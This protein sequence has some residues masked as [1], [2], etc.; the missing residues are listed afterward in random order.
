MKPT[1]ISLLFTL[2]TIPGYSQ[3]DAKPRNIYYGETSIGGGNFFM[4][5]GGLNHVMGKT[6]IETTVNLHLAGASDVP[7]DYYRAG[8]HEWVSGHPMQTLVGFDIL[9]GR[10]INFGNRR[11][12]LALKGG[13]SFGL[14]T[15]PTGYSRVIPYDS[16]RDNYD[17]TYRSKFAPGLVL[18]PTIEFPFIPYC[19]VAA[20]A[21]LNLNAYRSSA[22][23]E[24]SLLFGKIR[25]KRKVKHNNKGAVDL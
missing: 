8:L 24:A 1:I 17:I 16:T 15:A 23:I 4:I 18:N 5:K 11:T 3:D 9:A 22:G 13:I 14:Y 21:Y 6:V 2:L 12:R 20:G 19:G 10:I 25:N 7:A